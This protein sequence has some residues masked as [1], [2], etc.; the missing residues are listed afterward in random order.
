MDVP[1]RLCL[2]SVSCQTFDAV[3][4]K[5]ARR[6]GASSPLGELMDHGVWL[7]V[8]VLVCVCV[9]ARLCVCER[10]KVCVLVCECM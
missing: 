5:Q 9:R 1:P 10:E 7:C 3:D 2:P 6:T 8:C 4:G